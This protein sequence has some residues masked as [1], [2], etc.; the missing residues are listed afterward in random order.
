MLH[1]CAPRGQSGREFISLTRMNG[2][3]CRLPL[4]RGFTLVELLVVIAIIGI[5]IA[6]LLPAVQAARESARR[7]SCINNLRQLGLA[8]LNYESANGK[9][10]PGNLW[11]ANMSNADPGPRFTPNVVFLMQFLEEGPRFENY[12]RDIDWDDQPVEVL[13][14]LGSP[15]PTYQCPSDEPQR[16]T[17]TT[18]GGGSTSGVFNDAK[19]NYGLNWGSLFGFDQLDDRLFEHIEADASLTEFLDTKRDRDNAP[20]SRR[21]PFSWNFGAKMAQITDGTSHTFAMLE[22]LQAPTAEGAIDRRGRIWNHLPGSYHITT[23]LGPNGVTSP[24]NGQDSNI[25]GDRGTCADQPEINLPCS[26]SGAEFTMH[27]A[28][29][30]SHPSG[31]LVVMCDGS[32]HF[33]SDDINHETYQRLS[34]RDDGE[35]ASVIGN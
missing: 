6:L 8:H 25:R 5:L 1:G 19:G 20:G 10:S 28:S 27:M 30:S 23:Y 17:A 26:P 2:M 35:T 11:R 22:M 12:D 16:M 4:K 15:M 13:E 32:A 33:V 18:G 24:Y 21:A 9:L 34:V 29:R 3:R 14:A 7:S 31:V